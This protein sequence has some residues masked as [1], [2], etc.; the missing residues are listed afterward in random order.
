M[1]PVSEDLPDVQLIESTGD[2]ITD[3]QI[4]V[5]HVQPLHRLPRHLVLA[6]DPIHP[7]KLKQYIVELPRSVERVVSNNL[8]VVDTFYIEQVIAV[9]KSGRFARLSQHPEWPKWSGELLAGEFLSVVGTD[10]AD[11]RAIP[12][13]VID[14]RSASGD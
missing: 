5:G 14:I 11:D 12:P 6:T 4:W 3:R 10:W 1:I 7:K 9:T 2:L 13:Y 8:S